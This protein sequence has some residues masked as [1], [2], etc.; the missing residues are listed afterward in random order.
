MPRELRPFLL[1]TTALVLAALL[2]ETSNDRFWLSDFRVYWSAARALVDQQE[3]YGIAYGEDTGFFKYAP[4][5]ALAFVPA[6][7]LPFELAAVIH[8]M[9]IGLALAMAMIRMEEQLM[10]HFFMA[11]APRILLR[12]ILVLLCI[13]VLLSRELHVGNI[14]LWLVAGVVAATS[15]LL[16]GNKTSAGILL[17]CMFLVKPYL[18]LMIIP[19][20][21]RRQWPVLLACGISIAVGLA[22]PF[23]LLGPAR[24]WQLHVDWVHA[25]AAHNNYL[26]SPNTFSAWIGRI[27]PCFP[28]WVVLG[29]VACALATT[30]LS[31]GGKGVFP[32]ERSLCFELWTA[33]A[34]VPNLVVTDQEHFLFSLPLIA[35]V[36]ANLFH[37]KNPL[38]T[39]FFL[40]A[41]CLFATRSTD[42]WGSHIENQLA[43]YGALG[44]GNLLLVA[45]CWLVSG[46]R[47]VERHSDGGRGQAR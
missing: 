18:A 7:F 15:A 22:L 6:S 9:L 3:V 38:A 44:I 34:L 36:I 26:T 19:L 16:S 37:R 35:Y 40:L 23:L 10:R 2:L 17:G 24:A 45:C 29:L 32:P 27:W 28:S 11:F 14:N 1:I 30:G 33:F 41:M 8:F 13:V 25:M 47:L 4:V 21:V 31:K 46:R 20:L 42:L 43:A 12:A 39:G 5:V